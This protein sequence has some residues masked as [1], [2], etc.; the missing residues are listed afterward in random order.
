M[1]VLSTVKSL[2]IDNTQNKFGQNSAQ[3]SFWVACAILHITSRLKR[4]VSLVHSVDKLDSVYPLQYR[5]NIHLERGT[6]YSIKCI[7]LT[8]YSL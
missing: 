7:Y 3:I 6:L 4:S 5:V 1:S 8:Y 2:F